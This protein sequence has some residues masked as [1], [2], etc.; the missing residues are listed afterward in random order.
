MNLL[1]GS[2]TSTTG[3]IFASVAKQFNDHKLSWDYCIAIGLDNTNQNI[4]ERMKFN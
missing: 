2:T 4:G 1:E 3:S